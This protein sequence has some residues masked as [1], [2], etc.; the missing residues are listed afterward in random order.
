[1]S[2][3]LPTSYVPL[4]PDP[5][6][7]GPR[8]TNP[9]APLL[10]LLLRLFNVALAALA[11]LLIGAALWMAE[12]YRR[13][14][15]GG[16]GGGG[17]A[18]SPPPAPEALH[19]HGAAALAAGSLATAAAAAAAAAAAKA[20]AAVAGAGAAS[21]ASFPWFIYGVGG[22]GAYCLATA[23]AGLAGVRRDRRWHLSA[24]IALLALL[25][26]AQVGGWAWSGGVLV[27]AAS[28][29]PWC[30][31]LDRPSSTVA[32]VAAATKC[33]PSPVCPP[34]RRAGVRNA[35]AAHGQRLA[36]AHPGWVPRRLRRCLQCARA[37]LA[38]QGTARALRH[39]GLLPFQRSALPAKL[40]CADDPSG[41]WRQALAFLAANARVARLVAVAALGTEL[42]ALGAACWLKAI[43]EVRRAALWR[44]A[45]WRAVPRC[46][47]L[48]CAALLGSCQLRWRAADRAPA[49]PSA[50]FWL[51]HTPY[52]ALLYW[53]APA[54]RLRILAGGPGGG[55]PARTG[56]A[57][58]R[59][60][61]DLRG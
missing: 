11:L 29:A 48:R 19:P 59:R 51:A 6:P 10:R 26:L 28:P 9:L 34:P 18:P 27:A 32:L 42:A 21:V 56:R 1:M 46:A 57:R 30:H 35:G 5:L 31:A 41:R 20:A 23:L 53:F 43:Y 58:P 37:C 47:A 3:A 2:A 49:I 54:E 15:G 8:V 45:L 4:A 17:G 24:Y 25:V 22:T 60:A 36:G 12:S 38:D 14:G 55:E 7:P 44:A 13:D 40:A 33:S 16:G 61:A 52:C 39:P 50:F